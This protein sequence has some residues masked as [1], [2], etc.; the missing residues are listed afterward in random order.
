MSDEAAITILVHSCAR[1]LDG[2][3]VDAVVALFE[4]GEPS[5]E[6]PR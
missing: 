2:G 5:A 1:L 4:Q 3:D 6:A